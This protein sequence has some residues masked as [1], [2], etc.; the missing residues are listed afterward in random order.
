MAT[1]WARTETGDM[2][3]PTTGEGANALISD[4]TTWVQI[5]IVAVLSFVLGEW[6]LDTSLGFPWPSILGQKNPNLP[7]LRLLFRKTLAAIPFVA[8]VDDVALGFDPVTRNFTYAL[9]VTLTNG[10]T[11]SVP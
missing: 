8:S 4:L 1:T 10:Q 7:A 5:K 11:V 3:L 9:S 2:L 6:A